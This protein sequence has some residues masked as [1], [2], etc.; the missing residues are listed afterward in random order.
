MNQVHV[1]VHIL[2]QTAHPCKVLRIFAY[3]KPTSSLPAAGHS[4][5]AGRT[6]SP[7]RALQDIK[8]KLNQ[9]VRPQQPPAMTGSEDMS[10]TNALAGIKDVQ[11][12]PVEVPAVFNSASA[13]IADIDQRL[14]AL[15]TFLRAAQAGGPPGKVT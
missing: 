9:H 13:E 3:A 2:N 11:N 6:Q 14:H 1:A 12:Q 5:K 7:G 4:G 10:K 8:A 15:Q